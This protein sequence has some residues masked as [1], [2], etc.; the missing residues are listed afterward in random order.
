MCTLG[1]TASQISNLLQEIL[2]VTNEGLKFQCRNRTFIN[3]DKVHKGKHTKEDLL[4]VN[5]LVA[6]HKAALTILYCQQQVVP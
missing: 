1:W 6:K 3:W 2:K 4:D 5:K